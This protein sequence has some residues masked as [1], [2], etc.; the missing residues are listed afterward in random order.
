M[1]SYTGKGTKPPGRMYLV[2]GNAAKV[3]PIL[4]FTRDRPSCSSSLPEG[5]HFLQA[6]CLAIAT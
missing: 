6:G 2:S 5:C 3:V 1:S 4:A